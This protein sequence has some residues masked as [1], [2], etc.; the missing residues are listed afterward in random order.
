MYIHVRYTKCTKRYIL[1][2]SQCHKILF[3]H[4]ITFVHTLALYKSSTLYSSEVT[5]DSMS[6][7]PPP[8]SF[9]SLPPGTFTQKKPTSITRAPKVATG[10]GRPSPSSMAPTMENGIVSANPSVATVGEVHFIAI[11]HRPSLNTLSNKPFA[12][13]STRALELTR[14]K[15]SIFVAFR[16]RTIGVQHANP[17]VP[18]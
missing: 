8:L 14:D 9:F 12:V 3:V 18:R 11:A 6:S 17:I 10:V 16:I 2:I 7:S 5:I 13:I 15:S 1:K 4:I